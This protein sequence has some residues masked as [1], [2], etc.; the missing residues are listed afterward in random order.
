VLSLR[1]IASNLTRRIP[2]PRQKAAKSQ[3]SW[4][5]LKVGDKLQV[6]NGERIYSPTVGNCHPGTVFEVAEC[7]SLGV[8]I[9]VV[10]SERGSA[11]AGGEM[12]WTN[13]EWKGTFKKVRKAGR[14]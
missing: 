1:E 12:R 8:L 9:R 6:I 13:P 4:R 11:H 2:R 10:L 3:Q 14:L 5:T 7:D